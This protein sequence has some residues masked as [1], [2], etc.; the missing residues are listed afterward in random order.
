A[1]HL[2]SD[3]LGL[4][5]PRGTLLVVRPALR[6]ILDWQRTNAER[7]VGEERLQAVVVLVEDRI[8]LVVVAAGAAEGQAKEHGTR[9][10][11]DIVQ[12]LL[13]PREKPRCV[14]LVNPVSVETH[15]D[16]RLRVARI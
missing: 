2:R 8:V 3:V 6:L 7:G 9:G 15:P 10:I 14:G 12:G 11:G 4:F 13:P 16:K 5:F 1:G